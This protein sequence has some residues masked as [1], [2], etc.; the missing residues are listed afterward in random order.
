M[1]IA[2]WEYF[3]QKS[4]VFSVIHREVDVHSGTF[5]FISV[6]LREKME[7][8][9]S[10]ESFWDKNSMQLVA[11]HQWEELGSPPLLSLS[12][13]SSHN[14]CS[15]LLCIA[16]K[17]LLDMTTAV[18]SLPSGGKISP[19]LIKQQS[20]LHCGPKLMALWLNGSVFLFSG[21]RQKRWHKLAALQSR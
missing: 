5:V 9:C 3:N 12:L 16:V 18:H 21:W 10:D 20:S 6:C 4:T 11:L 19:C 8:R 7:Q 2:L 17:S 14:P 15:P 1:C 13:C